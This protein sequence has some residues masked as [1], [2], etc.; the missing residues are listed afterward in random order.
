MSGKIDER[1]TDTYLDSIDGV[2]ILHAVKDDSAHFLEALVATHDAHGT[3]LD[4]NV[5]LGQ[6][7]YG[8]ITEV[9]T[10]GKKRI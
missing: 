8:L 6:E 2:D 5:T 4:E 10:L 1:L 3:S 9:N 7:F